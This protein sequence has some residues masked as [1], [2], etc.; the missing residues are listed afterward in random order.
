VNSQKANIVWACASKRGTNAYTDLIG[1]PLEE[2]LL[3]KTTRWV[4]V[5]NLGYGDTW[6]WLAV[7]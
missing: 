6:K 5:I 4:N 7:M 3:G 2:L 1:N